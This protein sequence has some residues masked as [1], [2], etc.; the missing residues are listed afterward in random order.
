MIFD[1]EF[2]MSMAGDDPEFYGEMLAI[3]R[4]NLPEYLAKIE[5]SIQ[6]SDAEGVARAAHKLKGGLSNYGAEDSIEAALKVEKMAKDGDLSD[7]GSAFEELKV[8][9]EE[10]KKAI[11][12]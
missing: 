8:R 9:I 3:I 6:T 7:V 2:T 1:K 11:S 4:K 10:F 12:D 5:S